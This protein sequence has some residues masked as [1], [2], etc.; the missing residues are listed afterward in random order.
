MIAS[1]I[2]CLRLSEITRIIRPNIWRIANLEQGHG[3]KSVGHVCKVADITER[4][5]VTSTGAWSS[6][7]ENFI[8][9]YCLLP[10]FRRQLLCA[11]V[12]QL[13]WNLGLVLLI[14]PRCMGTCSLVS[15]Y[16]FV[17]NG[18]NI[19]LAFSQI[20]IHWLMGSNIAIS[21][22]SSEEVHGCAIGLE[23][24]PVK[25]GFQR[26]QQCHILIHFQSKNQRLR[27]ESGSM[28]F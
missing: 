25:L 20:A 2:F 19:C 12:W 22:G 23:E 3:A 13:Q 15:K 11:T 8:D 7:S 17:Y 9:M 27:V 5:C 10:T 28:V 4:S 1:E 16:A 6:R 26:A 21:L 24:S 18:L 14:Y